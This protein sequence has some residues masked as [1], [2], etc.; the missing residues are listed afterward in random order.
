MFSSTLT[1]LH[2]QSRPIKELLYPAQTVPQPPETVTDLINPVILTMTVVM[3]IIALFAFIW[4]GYN[5]LIGASQSDTNRIAQ[6][7]KIIYWT[8][9]GLVLLA[10]V[11]FIIQIIEILLGVSITDLSGI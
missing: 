11:F 10:A 4:A 9:I 8:L 5:Y 6:A 7:Q 2:A 1:Q 3:G